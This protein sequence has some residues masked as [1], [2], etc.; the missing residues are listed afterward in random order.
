MGWTTERLEYV[1]AQWALGISATDIAA[2]LNMSGPLNPV[3]AG[4]CGAATLTY[5][6]VTRNSIVGIAHRKGWKSPN[7][8][9][10]GAP[11]ASGARVSRPR[12]PRGDGRR[13]AESQVQVT[14][15]V[16]MGSRLEKRTVFAPPPLPDI[17]GD[18]AAVPGVALMDLTNR[19]CRWPIGDPGAADFRFCGAHGADN[20]SARPYCAR[21]LRMAYTLPAARVGRSAAPLGA[22]ARV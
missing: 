4:N 18:D 13:S 16:S 12:A 19:T 10:N 20:A 1:R 14:H 15:V 11:S 2:A 22:A 6:Y 9:K 8:W 5:G 17:N 7:S 21:H 3:V